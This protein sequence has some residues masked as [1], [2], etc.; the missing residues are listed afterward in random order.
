MGP[1]QK[2]NALRGAPT[3]GYPC[4]HFVSSQKFAF[5][6]QALISTTPV[7][8]FEPSI[9]YVVTRIPR[10]AFEVLRTATIP[11]ADPTLAPQMKSVGEA[12]AIGHP[13]KEGLQKCLSSLEPW[14]PC[15]HQCSGLGDDD[16]AQPVPHSVFVRWS[17]RSRAALASG[18]GVPN[19]G[20]ERALSPRYETGACE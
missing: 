14:R 15:A 7:A 6:G 3:P 20:M 16:N 8:L 4:S 5:C 19:V 17:N 11:Q 12:M 2:N 10:L 18:S 1:R 9:D 13:F